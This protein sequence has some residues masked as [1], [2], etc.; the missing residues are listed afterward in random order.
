MKICTCSENKFP[1]L[2]VTVIHEVHVVENERKSKQG[3]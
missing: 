1:R 3:Q 2:V